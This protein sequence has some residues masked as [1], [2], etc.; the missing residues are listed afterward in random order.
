MSLRTDVLEIMLSAAAGS[1]SGWCGAL[2]SP[3]R[4]NRRACPATTGRFLDTPIRHRL[5]SRRHL[6]AV[7][8]VILCVRPRPALNKRAALCARVSRADYLA[9]QS[10]LAEQG[11]IEVE[12][13][14]VP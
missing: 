4:A 5:R 6:F 12:G 10:I 2:G 1:Q 14:P 8:F 7:R 11:V 13:K 3:Y 9:D